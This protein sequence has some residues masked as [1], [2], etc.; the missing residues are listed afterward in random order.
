M[1]PSRR[2]PLVLSGP[3][4]PVGKQFFDEGRQTSTVVGISCLAD[5]LGLGRVGMNDIGQSFQANAGN[6]GQTDF[7][8]HLAGMAGNDGGSLDLIG[9]LFDQHFHESC[10]PINDS[11]VHFA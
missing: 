8:Y 9:S 10:L 2:T 11:P 7:A 6:K 5:G 1:D 3:A 4:Q